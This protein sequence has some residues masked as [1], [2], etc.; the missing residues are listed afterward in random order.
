MGRQFSA[1][2]G[3]PFLRMGITFDFLKEEIKVPVEIDKLKIFV[4]NTI[5]LLANNFTRNDGVP[6]T[7]ALYLF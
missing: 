4:S 6:S 5:M 1:N 2:L 7:P 3:F